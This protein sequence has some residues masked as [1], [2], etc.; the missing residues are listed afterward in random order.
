MSEVK[1]VHV[2]VGV[3]QNEE[4]QILLAK[5]PDD[6]HQGGKWEFPGGKVETGEG[7]LDA[8]V[9]EFREEVN[10]SLQP[11]SSKHLITRSFDYGNKRVVLDTWLISEFSGQPTGMEGQEVQWVDQDKL[12]SF[13]FPKANLSIL[14]AL[15][16]PENIVLTKV[17]TDRVYFQKESLTYNGMTLSVGSSVEDV[18]ELDFI[19]LDLS[20]S[21]YQDHDVKSFIARVSVPVLLKGVPFSKVRQLGAVAVSS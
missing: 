17:A 10:I 7:V 5:R 9:R 19:E 8:L 18:E 1:Q 11:T 2:A 15:L 14:W 3:V 20:G 13:D 12:W 16:M 4:G 6:K 21:P